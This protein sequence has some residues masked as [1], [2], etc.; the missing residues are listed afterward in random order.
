MYQRLRVTATHLCRI[1][2]APHLNFNICFQY[3]FVST[4]A[5]GKSRCLM[6]YPQSGS[7]Y[8]TR[9]VRIGLW[10]CQGTIADIVCI[11][12]KIKAE[13][14]SLKKHI[15][16]LP[17]AMNGSVK[18]YVLYQND[19]IK[20]VIY[21]VHIFLELEIKLFLCMPSVQSYNSCKAAT[22]IGVSELA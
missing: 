2:P 1:F 21:P 7:T 16:T 9:P 13:I 10:N 8:S 14:V 17:S 3:S 12:D 4:S 20:V 18:N 11:L 6:A 15:S 22:S 5:K 19:K